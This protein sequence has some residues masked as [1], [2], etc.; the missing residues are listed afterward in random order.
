MLIKCQSV[1]DLMLVMRLAEQ[2]L[3]LERLLSSKDEKITIVSMSFE[4]GELLG[5]RPAYYWEL[6][7]QLSGSLEGDTHI[8]SPDLSAP[9]AI[10]MKAV[11]SPLYVHTDDIEPALG[12][13]FGMDYTRPIVIEFEG[14]QSAH[15]L[16]LI[17]S[18]EQRDRDKGRNW[19]KEEAQLLYSHLSDHVPDS[20]DIPF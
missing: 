10:H 1:T 15:D 16:D 13:E 11:L 9:S 14:A 12:Q 17:Y 6:A 19:D 8:I 3:P 20:D 4:H 2:K 5:E 18:E 7:L